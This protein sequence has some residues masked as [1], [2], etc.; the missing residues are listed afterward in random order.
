MLANI[1]NPSMGSDILLTDVQDRLPTVDVKRFRL[2]LR[3][4]TFHS[5]WYLLICVCS[6]RFC[7]DCSSHLEWGGLQT[8]ISLIKICTICSSFTSLCDPLCL[9][10]KSKCLYVGFKGGEMKSNTEQEAE[11]FLCDQIWFDSIL[12]IFYDDVPF[13]YSVSISNYWSYKDSGCLF[14]VT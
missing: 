1:E 5:T 7:D 12:I 14:S 6:G 2:H 10:I 11:Y 3:V 8:I 4:F 13:K 9:F